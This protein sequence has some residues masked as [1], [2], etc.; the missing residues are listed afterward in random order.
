M[1]EQ[2]SSSKE[3]PKTDMIIDQS[4]EMNLQMDTKLT[5]STVGQ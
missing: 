4:V 2:V 5:A 3:Y 1:R